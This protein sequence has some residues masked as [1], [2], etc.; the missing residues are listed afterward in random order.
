MSVDK[1]SDHNRKKK[2]GG[3]S[4]VTGNSESERIREIALASDPSFD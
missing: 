3:K 1:S 4:E 2:K